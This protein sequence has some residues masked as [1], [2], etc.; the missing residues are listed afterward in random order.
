[1]RGSDSGRAG[2]GKCEGGTRSRDGEGTEGSRGAEE[3]D[4]VHATEAV[5]NTPESGEESCI[6]A[7]K[8]ASSGP[9]S[10]AD[11]DSLKIDLGWLL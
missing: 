9:S 4:T 11:V 7:V 3:M 10:Y 5:Q 6:I 1:M 8:E 2:G